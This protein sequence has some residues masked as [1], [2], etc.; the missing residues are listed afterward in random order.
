MQ[1]SPTTYHQEQ[2]L[3]VKPSRSAPL[4]LTLSTR[5]ST[6]H[7]HHPSSHDQCSAVSGHEPPVPPTHHQKGL[8][9]MV[10]LGVSADHAPTFPSQPQPP[11]CAFTRSLHRRMRIRYSGVTITGAGGADQVVLLDHHAPHSQPSPSLALTPPTLLTKVMQMRISTQTSCAHN[12]RIRWCC[13]G[14]G[15]GVGR[16]GGFS[17]GVG[18]D[19]GA[20]C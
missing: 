4:P 16:E 18:G 1:P 20:G 7:A 17:A 13:L 2:H 9:V 14:G 12:P 8:A 6:H 3:A 19:E 5:P 15:M 10:V 11:P